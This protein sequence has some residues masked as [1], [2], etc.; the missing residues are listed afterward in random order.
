VSGLSRV[1][2]SS[3]A[4]KVGQLCVMDDDGVCRRCGGSAWR[5]EAVET[6]RDCGHQQQMPAVER[7]WTFVAMPMDE[8][9]RAVARRFLDRLIE[10][11]I[12]R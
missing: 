10:P 4:V 1:T 7:L 9:E 2:L 11:V 3:P 6:C 12:R 5:R 8:T